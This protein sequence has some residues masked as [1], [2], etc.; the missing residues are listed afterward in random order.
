M[1]Q[2]DYSQAEGITKLYFNTLSIALKHPFKILFLAIIFS[3]GI[4]FTYAK[5]GLGVVFFPDVDPP[6]LTVKV[7]SHGDLSINE[8]DKLMVE[9]QD[10]ILGMEELDSVYTRTGGDDEIGQIQIT[11]V[12]WQYRR[13][14]KEIIEDLRIQTKDIAGIELEFSTPNAGPQVSMI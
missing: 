1:S 7:R 9:V 6:F 8:K 12:D 11:P 3:I 4:G 14:V 13:P 10:H 5:A 2:G